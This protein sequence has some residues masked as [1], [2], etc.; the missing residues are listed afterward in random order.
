MKIGRGIATTEGGVAESNNTIVWVNECCGDVGGRHDADGLIV[1]C[2]SLKENGVI[3]ERV[4]CL[5][6]CQNTFDV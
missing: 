6:S 1:K 5:E 4:A 2:E 3:I